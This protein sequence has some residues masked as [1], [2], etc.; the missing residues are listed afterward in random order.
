MLFLTKPVCF[1]FHV[2]HTPNT[3]TYVCDCVHIFRDL[4]LDYLDLYLIHWPI[5]L[6]E[7]ANFESPKPEELLPLDIQG[8]WKAMEEGVKKGLVKAIGV[9]NF[10]SNKIAQLLSFATIPPAVNQVRYQVSQFTCMMHVRKS[11]F[12]RS[13]RDLGCSLFDG[14]R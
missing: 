4:K 9:S 6:K 12:S 13:K 14:L 5:R 3:Y 1:G 10:S 8:T 7:G 11:Y 2:K